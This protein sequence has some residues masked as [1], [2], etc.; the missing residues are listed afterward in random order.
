MMQPA[1]VSCRLPVAIAGDL[2]PYQQDG[3]NWLA[4]LRHFHLH[5]VLADDMGEAAIVRC[6]GREGVL[7]R[8][9]CAGL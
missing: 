1:G 4:F 3:I 5:G 8:G 9:C 7:S 6:M 2:R